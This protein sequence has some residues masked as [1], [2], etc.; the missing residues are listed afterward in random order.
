M[1]NLSNNKILVL[2]PLLL[3]LTTF[4][5]AQKDK[6]N[7][8]PSPQSITVVV[9]PTGSHPETLA[10][11]CSMSISD[12][13]A[14]N[15]SIKPKSSIEEGAAVRVNKNAWS[16][17]RSKNLGLELCRGVQGRKEIAITLDCGYPTKDNLNRMLDL[18]DKHQIKA[19][20]FLTGMFLKKL[21]DA[22][23][24]IVARGHELGNHTMTHPHSPKLTVEKFRQELDG[25]ETLSAAS[26]TSV[27]TYQKQATAFPCSTKPFWRPPFGERS[28]E[29]VRTAAELG[30]RS[31][32]WTIDTLDWMT[33]KDAKDG[34]GATPDSIF[35]RLCERPFTKAAPGSDPLDGAIVLMHLAGQATPEALERII[36]HLKEKGYTFVT[37]NKMLEP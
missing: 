10:T 13:S 19:T 27:T 29:N 12:F 4:A 5:F 17:A 6:A 33:D 23:A 37:L 2:L 31:V 30:F 36:P 21:P 8:T 9:A 1:L 22:P 26:A 34:K 18:L 32:Y 11:S 15:P 35:Q 24:R 28:K 25:V 7:G 3:V 16:E 20:F 14:L